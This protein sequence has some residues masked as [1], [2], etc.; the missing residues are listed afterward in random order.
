MATGTYASFQIFPEHVEDG[1][2]ERL[3]DVYQFFNEAGGGAIRLEDA[4][5]PGHYTDNVSFARLATPIVRRDITSTAAVADTLI[6]QLNE[7]SIKL[8][9][10]IGP[11]GQTLDSFEKE[12]VDRFNGDPEQ[13]SNFFGQA[14]AEEKLKD[15]MEAVCMGLRGSL[16]ASIGGAA[17]HQVGGD[18][19]SGALNNARFKFGDRHRDFALLV[20]HSAVYKNLIGDQ[21]AAALLEVSAFNF[22]EGSPA[23]FGIPVVVADL[24]SLVN[25]AATPKPLYYSLLLQSGG[26]K[27]INS[28]RERFFARVVDGAENLFVRMQGEVAYNIQIK[29]MSY[30]HATGGINPTNATIGTAANWDQVVGSHKNLAGVLIEST[31]S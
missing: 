12:V 23:T 16:Q 13:I 19:T 17:F 7:V 27:V 29:G 3:A 25:A 10:R 4:R 20:M 28:E 11:F 15:M 6:Q 1:V 18:M 30:D 8:N 21:M 14:L 2:I 9:R 24:S 5:L 22:F 31:A 26:A